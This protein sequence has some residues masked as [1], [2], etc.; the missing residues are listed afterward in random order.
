MIYDPSQCPLKI[1]G[2][3]SPEGSLMEKSLL[4]KSMSNFD[5]HPPTKKE[6]N[7]FGKQ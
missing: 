7:I 1:V 4:N 6:K 5:L 3:L 2:I